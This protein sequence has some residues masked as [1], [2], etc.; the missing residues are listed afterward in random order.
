MIFNLESDLPAVAVVTGK[1]MNNM[2]AGILPENLNVLVLAKSGMFPVFLITF[3]TT[4][5]KLTV[6]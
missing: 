1:I 5:R 4:D 6:C 2:L 3:R